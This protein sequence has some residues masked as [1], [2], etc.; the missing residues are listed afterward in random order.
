MIVATN[1]GRRT[2]R[3]RLV[4]WTPPAG[5]KSLLYDAGFREQI[6][7]INLWYDATAGTWHSE[8]N[9]DAYN[10]ILA[11]LERPIPRP[12]MGL[13]SIEATLSATFQ[14]EN[15]QPMLCMQ[16]ATGALPPI[17]GVRNPYMLFGPEYITPA[18]DPGWTASPPVHRGATIPTQTHLVMYGVAF[19]DTLAGSLIEVIDLERYH[20]FRAHL[21]AVNNMRYPRAH[22][23]FNHHH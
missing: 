16:T 11:F 10:D 22:H 19:D 18:S 4:D 23:L 13:P 12:T 15:D 14:N 8:D 21:H 1:A 3:P 9:V 17:L 5:G 2:V 7:V 20:A 6:Q